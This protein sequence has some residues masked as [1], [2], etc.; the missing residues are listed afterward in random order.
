MAQIINTNISSL[1]AQRNLNTSQGANNTALERLSSGLRI[2]SAKDD[3]AGLAISTKFESQVKGL[4]VAIRNAGDGISLAQTA[5]GA[6]GAMTENLQRIRELAVQSSNA[7]NSDD[8]RVALQAEVKQLMAEVQRTAEETNFNGRNLLDGSFEGT[9]QIGANAGNTVEVKIT[10]LTADKLGSSAQAGVSASG[11]TSQLGN[12]DLVI[13]GES[14]RASVSGDDELSFAG[15]EYSGIA[16]AAAINASSESTGVVATVDEN[17]VV[18]SDMA[19]STATGTAAGAATIVLNGVSIDIEGTDNADDSAKAA[20]RGSVIES[21]NAKAEQTGVMASDGGND[22]G[23]ILTASDG[24]NITVTSAATNDLSVYGLADSDIT[25]AASVQSQAGFTLTSQNSSIDI[26]IAGG[27]GTGNGDITNSGLTAG[28]YKAQT[29]STS[30]TKQEVNGV[31]GAWATVN[32]TDGTAALLTAAAAAGELTIGTAGGDTLADLQAAFDDAG[33]DVTVGADTQQGIAV[34]VNEALASEKRIGDGDLVIN[35]VAI[36]ASS[37]LDDTASDTTAGS[38]DGA[39]SAIA[40]AAT[41]NKSSSDTGVT[42]EANAT[43]VVGGA[44]N[45]LGLVAADGTAAVLGTDVVAGASVQLTL[46]GVN[47]SLV[48]TE[49]YEKNKAGAIAA[50]NEVSGQTGV[51]ATDNGET[52]TLTAADGRNIS[53]FADSSDAG[54]ALIDLNTNINNFG[55]SGS[56]VGQNTGTTGL[57]AFDYASGA[58][59]TYGTVTLSSAKSFDVSFGTAGTKG[60][61][62]S[63]LTAGTFGGGEDGTFLKDVDIS[64]FQGAQDAITAIDNALKTVSSQRAELGALQN[65]FESTSSNLQITSENLSAANSRIRDADFAA[66]TAELSRTQVLQQAGISILAQANQKP[67]QVL[68]LLG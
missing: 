22:G 28:T 37:S 66:E 3:A 27:N 17:V 9:F 50:I 38:S 58:E 1:T 20:T 61:E 5:E 45:A 11:N 30:T 19:T 7:T 63:G 59:T 6:L 46:N 67:Q 39:A 56:S 48:E 55:L 68:S 32:S 21:I 31:D 36:K 60:L 24:R 42:A 53:L 40:I 41:I 51:V 16:K 25:A 33:F 34:A 65:R 15:K 49:D 29:A 10:E 57:K 44:K 2:N 54:E 8:D 13:N 14:I 23:V 12:G 43:E 4:N 62:D 64:T 52:L 47:V 18:G 26:E 35:G